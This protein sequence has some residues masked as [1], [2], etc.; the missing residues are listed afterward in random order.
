[1]PEFD[2]IIEGGNVVSG[3]GNPW[4]KADVAIS[5]GRISEI[6][7]NIRGDASQV[8]NA[9]KLCICPGFIDTH[10]HYMFQVL[11]DPSCVPLVRQGIT[12]A[13]FG[14]DGFS[15][16]P[17]NPDDA[18]LLRY[19]SGL[20]GEIP[21]DMK[22]GSLKEYFGK[23]LS[24]K[25]AMNVAML[26]GHGNVRNSV[27]GFRIERA[28]ASQLKEMQQL[29]REGM[30]DGAFGLSTGLIYPPS[31]YGDIEEIIELAQVAKQFGGIYVTHMRGEGDNLIPSIEEVLRISRVTGIPAQISHHK[32]LGKQNWGKV[33]TSVKMIVNARREGLDI[34]ADQYPYTA[35]STMFTALIPPWLLEGGSS[36]MLDRLRESTLREK[37]KRDCQFGTKDWETYANIPENIIISYCK[38]TKNLEGK[39]LD[40]IAKERNADP[41]LTI[42]DILNENEGIAS[43][44]VFQQDEEDMRFVL[45]TSF[46]NCCTDGL[47]TGKPH[48]RLYG[49]YPRVLGRYARDLGILSLEEAI[50]KM[51]SLPAQR[52]QLRDRGLVR[53]GMA[54]DLVAFDPSTVLDLSTYENPVQFP[55]GIQ[56]VIVNGKMVVKD[57]VLTGELPGQILLGPGYSR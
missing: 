25:S 48:P 42:F 2:I 16:F 57:E 33:R 50:R 52:L 5:A 3:D 15:A 39:T 4:F 35:G 7:P 30:M 10:S 44:V 14:Q 27:L 9:H 49:T 53:I 20:E 47:A 31:M 18:D 34:T 11:K 29:I 21:D 1:M 55:R 17:I 41:I 8:I 37:A 36:R 19:L 38:I 51:T 28:S 45:Q 12:T 56:Y 26:V 32:A 22:W 54:A 13:L 43:C 46:V 23:I 40:V 24:K 6:R